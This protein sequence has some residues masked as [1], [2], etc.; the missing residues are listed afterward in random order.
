MLDV[1]CK[2]VCDCILAI[3]LTE[4]C[5]S[6]RDGILLPAFVLVL[7]PKEFE[8]Y[9]GLFQLIVDVCVVWI[10]VH[11]LGCMLVRIKHAIDRIFIK[12]ADIRKGD[13]FLI[14]DPEDV[15]YGMP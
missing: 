13:T 1:I 3:A 9:T 4:L 5:V 12:T 6:H 10:P 7:L 11:S 8:R 2:L 14:S 15:T